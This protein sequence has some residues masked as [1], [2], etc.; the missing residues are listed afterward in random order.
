MIATLAMNLMLDVT[1]LKILKIM[2]RIPNYVKKN[3]VLTKQFFMGEMKSYELGW[4]NLAFISLVLAPQYPKLIL[5]S[6]I[7]LFVILVSSPKLGN[8][9]KNKRTRVQFCVPKCCFLYTKCLISRHLLQSYVLKAS[10]L[11]SSPCFL[12]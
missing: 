8:L 7:K 1:Y 2:I 4:E 10:N 3:L 9:F 6:L 11:Q 5:N 12:M